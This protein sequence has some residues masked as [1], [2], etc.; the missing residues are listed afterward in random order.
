M[1]CTAFGRNE[2]SSP[3]HLYPRKTRGKEETVLWYKKFS[4][5]YL[6]ARACLL[7]PILL[8]NQNIL[9]TL[10][11]RLVHVIQLLASNACIVGSLLFV[12]VVSRR[13]D[14]SNS[15]KAPQ[16]SDSLAI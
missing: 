14:M 11:M 15:C 4:Y 7:S 12:F 5:V 8:L 10:N 9:T 3:Q 2:G 13:A 1:I 6:L 16:L